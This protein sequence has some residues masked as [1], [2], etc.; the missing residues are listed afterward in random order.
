MD[1]FYRLLGLQRAPGKAGCGKAKLVVHGGVQRASHAGWNAALVAGIARSIAPGIDSS[2]RLGA[3]WRGRR[4]RVRIIRGRMVTPDPGWQL[5][6]QRHLQTGTRT[7]KNGAVPLRAAPHLYGHSPDVF[8][9]GH[10]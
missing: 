4:L 7:Y 8:W 9:A 5:E 1:D 6:Q 3:G 10:S 2:Y